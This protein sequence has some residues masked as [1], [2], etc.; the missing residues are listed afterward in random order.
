MCV[1]M[2]N[3]FTCLSHQ[4]LSHSLVNTTQQARQFVT[5]QRLKKE[6]ARRDQDDVELASSKFKSVACDILNIS[7]Q[8]LDD[9]MHSQQVDATKVRPS[10]YH[11]TR[12]M[13]V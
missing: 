5:Q 9:I 8:E 11:S 4:V 2:C 1:I 3:I 7:D 10:L 6:A 13:L 12:L